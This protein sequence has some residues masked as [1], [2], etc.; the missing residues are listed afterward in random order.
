MLQVKSYVH[1]IKNNR[2]KSNSLRQFKNNQYN[3]SDWVM[4][5]QFQALKSL[6]SIKVCPFF[7]IFSLWKHEIF[8][9][10]LEGVLLVE[11]F[12]FVAPQTKL[13]STFISLCD[14][15]LIIVNYNCVFS[16]TTSISFRVSK[17]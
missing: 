7:S 6:S 4:S 14:I 5:E 9:F 13:L 12:N 1:S 11:F 17:H 3:G 2:F 15:S 16:D 10:S 8:A